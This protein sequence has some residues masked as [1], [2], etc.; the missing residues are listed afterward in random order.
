MR[1]AATEKADEGPRQRGTG[2]FR[3][4]DNRRLAIDLAEHGKQ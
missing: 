4:D 1:P 2:G 3:I